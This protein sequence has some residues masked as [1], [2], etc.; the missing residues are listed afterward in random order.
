MET[1]RW[2]VDIYVHARDDIEIRAELDGTPTMGTPARV[3]NADAALKRLESWLCFSPVGRFEIAVRG[4]HSQ[5]E[6]HVTTSR[7]VA[8]YHAT[9]SVEHAL[10]AL[11]EHGRKKR[12]TLGP[13]FRLRTARVHLARRN[14]PTAAG[15]LAAISPGVADNLSKPLGR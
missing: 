12:V 14:S 8:L 2:Q 5:D 15:G 10:L 7:S 13:L 9:A 11:P 6:V 4:A 3:K 1:P